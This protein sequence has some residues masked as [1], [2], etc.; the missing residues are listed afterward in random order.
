MERTYKCLPNQELCHS[1]YMLV[2]IRDADKYTIMHWRNEQ[3]D[4]LRQKMVLTK[5]VQKIYFRDVVDK[6]FNQDRPNQLL[7]SFLENDNLIGYGGL[8]HIDWENKNAEMSFLNATSRCVDEKLFE[9]DFKGYLD[10]ITPTAFK[11]LKF[12]KIH[13]TLYDIP[14]RHLYKRIIQEYGFIKEAR[15]KRHVIVDSKSYDVCIYSFFN[16][17]L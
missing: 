15:L 4:I 8:V 3:I 12:V 2:P 13:T 16:A 5:Q 9:S 7:F 6:L 11:H 17:N 10:I 1:Q 14:E